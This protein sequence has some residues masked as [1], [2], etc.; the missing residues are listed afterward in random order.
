MEENRQ[1]NKIR[2]MYAEIWHENE[3]SII[4]KMLNQSIKVNDQE[5]TIELQKSLLN[6]ER[7]SDMINDEESPNSPEVFDELLL[8]RAQSLN[9]LET[10]ENKKKKYKSNEN[11][12]SP[13]ETKYLEKV[14]MQ[15]TKL[16][17]EQITIM[18]IGDQEVGKTSLMNSWLGYENFNMTKHTVGYNLIKL[19]GWIQEA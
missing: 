16:Y 4:I 6:L 14:I 2:K 11:P 17:D 13:L 12:F 3:T 19:L 18:I 7:K 1:L 9:I 8:K 15:N 5:R 10:K